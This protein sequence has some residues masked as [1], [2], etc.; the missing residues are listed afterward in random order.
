MKK[1]IELI[2]KVF[3]ALADCIAPII[4][5]LI[6]VGMLKVL[7][8][9]LGPT[10]LN[11]LKEDSDTYTVLSFVADAGYYFMPI[12]VAVSSADIFKTDRFLA[13]LTGG[14]LVSPA[15]VQMVEEGRKLSV[16][17]LPVASTTYGNQVLP[18]IIAVFILSFL[19][20][21]LKE[22]I[23]EKV[24]GVLLPL[25]TILIM[26]PIAFCAIGP[27]GVFLGNSLISLIMLLKR[28][29]PLGNALL[30]AILPVCIIIG[31]GGA[32]L[33]AMLLLSAAGPDPILFF[34][35]VLYNCILGAV[36]F[37][38]YLKD[39]KTETLAASIAAIVGGA[40]EPAIYGIIIKDMK[41]LLSLSA[42]GFVAGL[43]SGIFGVKTFAMA[44]FGIFG[45][46]ATIGPGSSILGAV[47]SLIVG[48]VCGFV[49]SFLTHSRREDSAR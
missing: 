30:C 3:G 39:K 27:L 26:V 5:I 23:P 8:I 45:I 28:L 4:P 25:L 41:G 29:G 9:V 19:Y 40:S 7:L 47:I 17:G 18:S 31:L 38:I 24:E 44:S 34:S 37:A 46:L 22:I 14:M 48:C 32:D 12:Y 10:I 33:S 49:L 1:A 43:L 6:G 21:K 20:R 13:A 36:T 11:V 35:N 16:F 42:G 2:K 15:F